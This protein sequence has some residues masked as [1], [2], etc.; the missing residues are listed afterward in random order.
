[1]NKTLTVIRR[2]VMMVISV[3]FF[4][5]VTSDLGVTIVL[6]H[7]GYPYYPAMP[8]FIFLTFL[9]LTSIGM[10]FFC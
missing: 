1:M 6:Y 4:Y 7:T 8:E 2:L 9:L 5:Q 10:A 3:V